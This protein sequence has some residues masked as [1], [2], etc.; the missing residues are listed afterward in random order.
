MQKNMTGQYWFVYAYDSTNNQP[1]TGDAANITADLYLD[2]GTANAVDDT[3]PTEI[4]HGYYRFDLTQ[5]ETNANHILI[6]PVSVTANILVV[7]VPGSVYTTPPY[8]STLGIAPDGDLVKVNTL[9]GH[10]PQTADH[11]DA[12]ATAQADLDLLTGADGATLATLQG[13]YA[14]AKAGDLMGLADDAI[15]SAKFDELTAFPL[16]SADTGATQVAR[17]GADSDTLETLSDQIDGVWDE[18]AADH[19][20]AGSF[21]KEVGDISAEVLGAGDYAV[22]LTIR[23]T[24]GTALAGVS[25]WLNTTNTRSGSVAGTKVTNGSGQVTFNLNYTT[26]YVFCQ[27]AGYTFA[28]ASFTAASGSVSF[29]K[30]IASATVTGSSSFYSDSFLS[31]GIVD[32]REAL[33]EPNVSAKYTDARIIEHLEKAYILVLNEKNR[34]DKTIAVVKQDLTIS[35]NTTT[36]MLPY[37]MGSF[38]GLYSENDSGCKVFYDERSKYNPFG[39]G[40]WLE[41][42]TL[43]IQSVGMM[44][45]GTRL[46]MEWVPSGIAR[47]HN[48]VC[49]ISADG[50]TVTLGATPNAGMLDTHDN[51]Y[52]GGVLRILGVNGTTVTGNYLQERNITAYDNTTRVATLDVALDPI[53][54]TDD[55]YIY[56]EIAPAIHKGMDM[57]VALYAAYRIMTV[58]GNQKRAAGILNAYRNELRNVRLS[59]Y[60]TNMPS[61]PR[62]PGDNYDNRRY[63]S[64]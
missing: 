46:K 37:T 18:A 16:T 2:G 9:D 15:T 29:T 42:H 64:F 12:L 5:P 47:L 45:I 11:T 49:T 58:E 48:G 19:V 14:P 6:D 23:T 51:A 30:D 54:T 25:V 3:N 62:I 27:L 41:G 8:F 55:G 50:L 34:Q 44:G 63:R 31:R 32:V 20:S 22:T 38:Y 35:A 61:A 24:G 59:T 40:V 43:H 39:Q 52:S 57:V 28:A 10:T 56:Y 53:P 1:K 36:Y 33:D 21:G 17:V 4:G 60:Y 13:N 26:Y 7:G